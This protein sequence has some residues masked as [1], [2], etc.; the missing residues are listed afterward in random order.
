MISGY[1]VPRVGAY[2]EQGLADAAAGRALDE[3]AMGMR[4]ANLAYAWQNDLGDGKYP[5]EP[6]GDPVAVSKAMRGKY[7]SFFEGC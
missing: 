4:L 2:L 1:Y 7:A 6:A 5:T 3:K